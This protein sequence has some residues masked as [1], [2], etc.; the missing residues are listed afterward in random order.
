LDTAREL[1]HKIQNDEQY[2]HLKGLEIYAMRPLT[3]YPD[4]GTGTGHAFRLIDYL[5]PTGPQQQEQQ[6]QQQLGENDESK[7]G[8]EEPEEADQFTVDEPASKQWSNEMSGPPL[9]YSIALKKAMQHFDASHI[10][11]EKMKRDLTTEER[12]TLDGCKLMQSMLHDL[13]IGLEKVRSLGAHEEHLYQQIIPLI[14]DTFEAYDE[15]TANVL[16]VFFKSYS[17]AVRYSIARNTRQLLKTGGDDGKGYHYNH[18]PQEEK[19]QDFALRYL[20]KED[21]ISKV[22]VGAT[23]PEHVLS[24]VTLCH[25]LD[26]ELSNSKEASE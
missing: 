5:L 15:E 13:D 4:R 9:L 6:Q 1:Y 17:L 22:I 26:D 7:A 8:K 3:C 19:L 11:E 25:R 2:Q 12:E 10:L 16:E 14:H 24:I 21:A 20:M 23:K 18:M